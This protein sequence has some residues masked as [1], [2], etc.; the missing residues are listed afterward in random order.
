M[1][2]L[3][4]LVDDDGKVW[5]TGSAA[6]RR[7]LRIEERDFD[8]TGYLIRNMGF[9]RFRIGRTAGRIVVQPRFLTKAT[10]ESLVHVMI[11]HE[12]ARFV[13]ETVDTPMPIEI[14]PDLE[15]AVSR[16]SDLSAV[17]GNVVRG[18]FSSE[19]LSLCRL[20]QNSR[21]LP[22]AAL[23]HQWRVKNGVLGNNLSAELADP[24][25][26]GRTLMLRVSERG[27]E[28]IAEHVG[29]G[30]SWLSPQWRFSMLGQGVS[31]QPDPSYGKNAA[32]A[33][34]DTDRSQK[35]RL[36][37]V[38]AVIKIPG[39]PLRHARYQRLL[40]PWRRGSTRFV[41]V[42]SVVRIS[43]AMTADV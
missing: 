26:L 6:L 24:T 34:G 35:P 4:V 23:L 33:Y 39:S 27:D 7:S 37:L 11:Q 2:G 12:P 18:D 14:F 21:L 5:W 16:L 13:I 15:D 42:A 20:K 8:L 40:L 22:L 38:D 10:F 41:S 19:P 25:L 1:I 17:G 28:G 3:D 32:T 31:G 30:F 43:A 9:A 36:E 29:D